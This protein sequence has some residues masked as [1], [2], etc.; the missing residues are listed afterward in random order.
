MPRLEMLQ[1][2]DRRAVETFRERL[3]MTLGDELVALTLFGSKAR[4]QDARDSDI[5]IMVVVGE[6]TPSLVRRVLDVAFD[7]NLTYDVYI[8]PRVISAS[9]LQ[10]PFW[11]AT[12]FIQAVEREGV[13]I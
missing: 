8:S 7:V 2:N 11:R 3:R 10:D 13:A 9:A 1:A 12:P 6:R 5:D 4:G